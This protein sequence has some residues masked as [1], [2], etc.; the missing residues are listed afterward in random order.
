MK[1]SCD[2]LI[3][4]VLTSQHSRILNAH[5]RVE[6]RKRAHRAALCFDGEVRQVLANL[7]GNAVDAMHPGGGRLVVRSR[8]GRDWTTGES[9]LV[10]TV[11]DTG[12]G[13]SRE[14]RQKVFEAFF[15]T[16]GIAGTGLGLWISKDIMARHRGRM[17]LRS[18]QG[19]ERHGTVF[20]VYLPFEAAPTGVAWQ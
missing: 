19:P 13:M 9:V 14:V 10:I 8:E 6:T 16:K 1:V 11:A 7:I 2:E 17:A 3:E 20:I 12:P 18:S 5:V 4:P 15:T